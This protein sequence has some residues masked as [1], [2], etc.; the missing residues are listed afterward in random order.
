MKGTRGWSLGEHQSDIALDAVV[1]NSALVV[2]RVQAV[3]LRKLES[4][5]LK[6]VSRRACKK[7][8]RASSLCTRPE[9]PATRGKEG[10]RENGQIKGDGRGGEE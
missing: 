8:R 1:E 10:R 5:G 3:G 6:V 9:V 2:E 4:S 7:R